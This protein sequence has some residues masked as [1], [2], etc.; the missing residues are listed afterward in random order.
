MDQAAQVIAYFKTHTCKVRAVMDG[1]S[2]V[3]SAR[4]LV[5]WIVAGRRERFTKRDAFESLKGTFKTVEDLEPTLNL[6]EKHGII[7]TEQADKRSGPGRK[8]SPT[9]EANPALWIHSHYSQN[10]APSGHSANSANCAN[11]SFT[12]TTPPAILLD[13][14]D[15]AMF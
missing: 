10:W 6:A 13:E 4:K 3:T 15:T 2:R 5:R 11:G 14:D 7:R 9:F 12:P 8:P 1:D